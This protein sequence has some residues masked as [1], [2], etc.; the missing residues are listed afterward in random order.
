M[1]NFQNIMGNFSSRSTNKDHIYNF[2]DNEENWKR[3][4]ELCFTIEEVLW[5]RPCEKRNA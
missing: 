2:G 1:A 5:S 3:F 4:N